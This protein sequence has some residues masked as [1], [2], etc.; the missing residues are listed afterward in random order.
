MPRSGDTTTVSCARDSSSPASAPVTRNPVPMRDFGAPNGETRTRTGDTTIFSRVAYESES[1]RFAGNFWR[2]RC[3]PRV[4]AFS[5]FAL[6]STTLRQTATAVCLF[7]GRPRAQTA[8]LDR[9]RCVDDRQRTHRAGAGGKHGRRCL[10]LDP[11]RSGTAQPRRRTRPI[12]AAIAS[13]L[14]AK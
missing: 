13:W 8:Q 11:V 2:Y 5:D 10:V 9:Y 1:G 7:V 4:R 14:R 3:S 6:V 12:M